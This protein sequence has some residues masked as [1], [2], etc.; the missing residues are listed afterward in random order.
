MTI[1][2]GIILTLLCIPYTIIE[3][4]WRQSFHS[5][6]LAIGRL[7]FV[8]GVFLLTLPLLMGYSNPVGT[9][10]EARVLQ[11]ISKICYSSYL[12]HDIYIIWRNISMPYTAY[13][14]PQFL[15]IKSMI[16]L[17]PILV[18]GFLLTISI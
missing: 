10:L 6:Y 12:F 1:G 8:F 16:D 5:I 14:T 17:L 2:L 13:L 4:D 15:L 3:N 18:G 7:V 11:F 9:L